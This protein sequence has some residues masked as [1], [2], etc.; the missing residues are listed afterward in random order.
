MPEIAV[1]SFVT[2][3]LCP[4]PLIQPAEFNFSAACEYLPHPW[5]PAE[6]TIPVPSLGKGGEG[7]IC[8]CFVKENNL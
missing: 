4:G 2:A 6:P 5:R 7:L 1:I 3:D 8:C